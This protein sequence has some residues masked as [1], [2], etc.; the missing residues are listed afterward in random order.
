MFR[1]LLKRTAQGLFALFV[2]TTIV[3]FMFRLLPAD[4]T[5]IL[6]GDALDKNEVEQIQQRFGLD[7]PLLQQY[8]IYMKNI[9]VDHDFGTSFYY[10]KPVFT[11][12][13]DK[14]INTL[15][16]SLTGIIIAYLI[17]IVLG[18]MLAWRRGTK[19]E[20]IGI[21]TGLSCKAAPQFWTGMFVIMFFSY[22]LGWFP[23]SGMR[24]I[25]YESTTLLGKYLSWDFI[26]HLILPSFVTVLYYLA[27]P[28]LLMRNAM[29]EIRHEDYINLAYSKGLP[30]S[31]IIFHHAVRNALLPVVTTFATTIGR[32]IGGVILIEYVFSWPGLGREIVLAS[33]RYDYPLAQAAFLMIAAIVTVM[34]ILAD[35]IYG[36]LDPRIVYK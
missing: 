33:T 20:I 32:A 36:Y 4:P 1:F 6:A 29:L 11:I 8:A 25:G 5:D 14:I 30:E 26:H 9:I 23:A 31:R 34:N 10:Q 27:L 13:G 15:V 2:L 35:L 18:A 24:D 7:K 16:L 22:N 3:F 17:G 28:M 12:L 19:F 21:I